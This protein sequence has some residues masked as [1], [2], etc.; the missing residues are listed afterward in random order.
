MPVVLCLVEGTGLALVALALAI[1]GDPFPSQQAALLSAAAGIAGMFGL[2]ALYRA[3]AVGTMSV[4]A[5]IS[6]CGVA[7]PVVVGLATGDAVPTVVAIGLASAFGGIVLASLE[8]AEEP[9]EE[10][11]ANRQAVL[12]ALVAAAGFGTYFVLADDAADESVLW[13]LMLSRS[14]MLPF[15]AGAVLYMRARLP[16]GRMRW[17]LLGAGTLDVAATWLYGVATTK[18]ALSVVSVVGSLFPVVTVVLARVVLS[19]RLH[20]LQVI[21]VVLAFTGVA[22]IA[23]G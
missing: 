6:A 4:V 8:V 23:A 11:R 13:L 17:A 21:G 1:T 16:A 22:L 12:L 14:A 2:G 19:E 5:P 7:L 9:A 10:R 15:V 3:L 18:G 20:R